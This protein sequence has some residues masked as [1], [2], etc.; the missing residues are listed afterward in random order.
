MGHSQIIPNVSKQLKQQLHNWCLRRL[1]CFIKT[2][3][4]QIGLGLKS[5]LRFSQRSKKK[6]IN[7]TEVT[8]GKHKKC[9]NLRKV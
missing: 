5:C 1:S 6:A 2:A 3:M 8:Y 4:F 7:S 9:G